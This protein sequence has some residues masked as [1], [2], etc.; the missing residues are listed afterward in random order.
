MPD[1]NAGLGAGLEAGLAT[2]NPLI[3]LG[4]GLAS[5][6]FSKS[7]EEERQDRMNQLRAR[8]NALKTTA[9]KGVGTQT[10]GQMANARMA[11]A[12]QAA[13]GGT[14]DAETRALPTVG[15]LGAEGNRAQ[16]QAE[17]SYDRML[18]GAEEDFAQRP[19]RP[20]IGTTLTEL[21]G[22]LVQNIQAEKA[23][24]QRQKFN[25]QYLD[26]IR[27][28]MPGA[29]NPSGIS[30]NVVPP[31]IDLTPPS[32]VPSPL[33]NANP[34]P[35]NTFGNYEYGSSYEFNPS[36]PYGKRYKSLVGG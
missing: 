13:A 33:D 28:G 3:G 31:T 11:A 12:R 27:G 9:M 20:N 7:P 22:S 16:L 10:A 15:V 21:G 1:W 2:G 8:I 35:G 14:N 6:L 24:K 23:L 18:A 32:G 36:A 4:V 29:E 26:L 30:P 25:Q 34:N 17:Q 19:I 5:S